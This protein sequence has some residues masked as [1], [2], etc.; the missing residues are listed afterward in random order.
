MTSDFKLSAL[1]AARAL[2]LGLSVRDL[3]AKLEV[4]EA[5]ARQILSAKNLREDNIQRVAAALGLRLTLALVENRPGWRRG[6]G[7]EG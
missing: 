5:R 2:E 6:V 3:A 1:F 7:V 4:S